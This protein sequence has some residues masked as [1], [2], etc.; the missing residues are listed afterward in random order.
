MLVFE[1][2]FYDSIIWIDIKKLPGV[3][4]SDHL[5]LVLYTSNESN[6]DNEHKSFQT[7]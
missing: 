4:H 3:N 5:H 1:L 7:R 6:T 2:L